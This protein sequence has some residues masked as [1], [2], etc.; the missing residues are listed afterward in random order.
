[1][2]TSTAFAW[3]EEEKED[4]TIELNYLSSKVLTG[5][6]SVRKIKQ[7]QN[8]S[9]QVLLGWVKLNMQTWIWDEHR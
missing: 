8:T 7:T 9:E 2:K 6:S 1:M 3:E 5:E 4:A